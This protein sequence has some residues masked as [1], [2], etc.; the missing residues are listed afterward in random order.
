MKQKSKWLLVSIAGIAVIAALAAIFL[1]RPDY[2]AFGKGVY[3]NTSGNLANGGFVAAND[4]WIYYNSGDYSGSLSKMRPDGSEKTELNDE[5]KSA[6]EINVADGWIY[7][8]GDL[9][10]YKMRTDGT[11]LLKMTDFAFSIC[12]DDGWLYYVNVDKGRFCLCKMHTDGTD[13]T[14]LTEGAFRITV[15]DGW[16]YY[17]NI[18]DDYSLNKIRVDGTDETKLSG[19]ESWCITV[20]GDYVYFFTSGEEYHS[21]LYKIR[22]DGT[23]EIKLTDKISMSFNVSN[24]WI[25]YSNIDDELSLHKMR[26]D[27]TDDVKIS[28]KRIIFSFIAGDWIYYYADGLY[29]MKTDGTG[30]QKVD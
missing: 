4:G 30:N 7:F 18:K 14:Q 12:M 25:Y 10:L 20:S 3:G 9:G 16:I 1:F 19:R 2:E 29:R 6:T 8:R 22:T 24:G 27:G 15:A 5:I 28:D 17:T 21:D 23:E 11:G 13:L 26:T